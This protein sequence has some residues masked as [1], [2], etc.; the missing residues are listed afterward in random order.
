MPYE[1]ETVRHSVNIWV[2]HDP[3]LMKRVEKDLWHPFENR[4]IRDVAEKFYVM[5]AVVNSDL[6]RLAK[7]RKLLKEHPRLIVFYNFNYELAVLRSLKEE[8][9]YAEWNGHKHEDLPSGDKWV[10]AVQ[11]TA[12]AEGWNCIETN[13]I[14]FWSLTYSYK[15]WEQAHGRIDRLNTPFTDLYYYT[16]RSRAQIDWAIWR[17]LKS[18]KSFQNADYALGNAQFAEKR[19]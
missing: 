16:F 1:K 8:M 18:K 14:L 10:Y 7:L 2:E 19:V 15:L 4:P 5:R 12:G 17:S 11:Y 9:T 13:A 3:E 6:S